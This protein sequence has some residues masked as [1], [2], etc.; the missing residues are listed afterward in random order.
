MRLEAHHA[1]WMTHF[2]RGELVAA[3]HH[4]D[5]GEPLY[6]AV[7]DRTSALTYGHDAKAAAISYRS[8]LLWSFGRIDQALDVERQAL[9]HARAIGHPMSLAFVL[10]NSG[11]LR[12][13]RREPEA[14]GEHADAVIA[15]STEQQVPFWMAHGLLLRGWALT[16]RGELGRG[17]ADIE[18]GLA[19]MSAMSALG[20]TAHGAN[21]AAA[22]ARS[23]DLVAARELMENVKALVAATGERYYEPEIHRLDAELVLAEAGAH[24][25]ACP[26]RRGRG[27]TRC[28]TRPSRARSSKG[29]RTMELRAT[30]ML[31]RLATGRRRG[32]CAP[33][34]P[35]CSP[36]SPRAPARPTWKTRAVCWR[37]DDHSVD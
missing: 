36:A 23:G 37:S 7:E 20:R 33:G 3:L 30:T 4:L 17:I 2:F 28:S 9:S 6:D 26:P 15:Y 34:S 31:A 29:A 8:I 21:L 1:L 19:S 12:I 14:C 11:W 5:A 22:K 35:S 18:E 27:R 10:V 16:E 13:L 24:R 32:R 25:P